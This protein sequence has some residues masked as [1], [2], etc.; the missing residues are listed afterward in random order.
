MSTWQSA[1]G[2]GCPM[3]ANKKFEITCSYVTHYAEGVAMLPLVLLSSLRSAHP[4][5]CL[6][7]T[8]YRSGSTSQA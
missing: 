7:V 4:G 2:G 3:T 1:G 6:H 5:R 8:G